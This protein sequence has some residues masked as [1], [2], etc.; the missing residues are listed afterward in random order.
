MEERTIII[1]QGSFGSFLRGLAVGAVIALLFAP[2]SGED[3][4]SML[5]DR[6]MQ[7]RDQAMDI[8]KDIPNRAQGY[9]QDARNKINETIQGVKQSA[10]DASGDSN[11]ELKRELEIMEEVNNPNYNV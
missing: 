6:G 10:Q 11:K 1:K 5:K 7:V 4:R 8:A 2:R 3:T 9:M